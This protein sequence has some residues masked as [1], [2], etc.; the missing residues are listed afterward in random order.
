MQSQTVISSLV[1]ARYI[2]LVKV[3]GEIIGSLNVGRQVRYD[4]YVANKFGY[5]GV[6]S[7]VKLSNEIRTL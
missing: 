2:D 3:K 1:E 7:Q 4:Q 6:I 5:L